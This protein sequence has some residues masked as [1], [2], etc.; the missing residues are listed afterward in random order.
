MANRIEWKTL[1]HSSHILNLFYIFIGRNE[2]PMVPTTK[3]EQNLHTFFLSSSLTLSNP[4]SLSLS[5]SLTPLFL[6][7]N[8]K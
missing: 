4:F 2:N 3:E 5:I 1:P 7:R 6:L 8:K